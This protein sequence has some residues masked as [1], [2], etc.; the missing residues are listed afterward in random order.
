MAEERTREQARKIFQD[1]LA[2]MGLTTSNGFTQAE[3]DQLLSSVESWTETNIS[4]EDMLMLFRTSRETSAIYE[5]RFPGMKA[6]A[7]R[8]QAIS[9]REYIN[10]EG[11][12]RDV[13][14]SSGLPSRYYDSFDDY[15]RFIAG[16]VSV[17]EVEQR[18]TAARSLMNPRIALELEEYYGIGEGM[19]T[20]FL[21]GLT[22]EK[23]IM[24][25]AQA[26][27]RNQQQLRDAARTVQIGGMAEAAGFNMG[28]SQAEL[29]A[30]TA[31]G[32]GVDPFGQQTQEQ[33]ETKF[34]QARRTANR[35]STLAAIDRE[36][37]SD[38]DTLQAAFG[39]DQKKL[40]S[41]R[42][43]KRERAR[44]QGSAGAS[45]GSLSVERNL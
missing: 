23:G 40:A 13:L 22:D 32:R 45:S 7:S 10:L 15:G 11:Q 41:E 1:M 3:I 28:R 24:L 2:G 38:M 25:D 8:A 37:Y 6:L 27:A 9:E 16:G 36:T 5:K 44:F 20:A 18:V 30:G 31:L 26:E 14:R 17:A 33:L 12:Y 19:A 39:D 4:D 21:L 43:A 29:L 42:R 35:E 34:N